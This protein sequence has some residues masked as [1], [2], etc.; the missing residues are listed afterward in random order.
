MAFDA[1][2]QVVPNAPLTGWKVTGQDERLVPGPNGTVQDV[3]RVSFTVGGQGPY[4]V[5]LPKAQYSEINV[6]AAVAEYAARLSAV[7]GLSG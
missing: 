1:Q 4:T 3:I 7:H 5:D 6:R 2:G